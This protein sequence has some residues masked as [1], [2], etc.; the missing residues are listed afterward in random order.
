MVIKI[1]DVKTAL[2]SVIKIVTAQETKIYKI[3]K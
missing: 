2:P 1:M 3:S